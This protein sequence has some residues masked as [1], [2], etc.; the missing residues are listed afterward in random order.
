MLID[1]AGN[2]SEWTLRSAKHGDVTAI[3]DILADAPKAAAWSS[4]AVREAIESQ[5]KHFL[6]AAR[7]TEIAGL[8]LGRRIGDEGEIL[9]LAVRGSY[10]RKGLGK[11]L[12]KKLLDSFENDLVSSVFLE[13]R[14][15]NQAAIGF[16]RG[17][18]FTQI[19][20]RRGYYREPEE[21]ALVL[22]LDLRRAGTS[23]AR[24]QS[25]VL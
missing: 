20:K 10:R 16:Y 18:G 5:P 21:A 11:A 9:N 23:K 2:E 3:L 17:L 22:R 12:L 25:K 7:N 19:A 4:R 6:V 8:A 24:L 14:E 15:S 1:S 13:V